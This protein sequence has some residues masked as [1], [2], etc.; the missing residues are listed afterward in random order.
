MGYKRLAHEGTEILGYF[1]NPIALV[2]RLFVQTSKM[3][4]AATPI[5]VVRN[6]CRMGPRVDHR[7]VLNDSVLHLN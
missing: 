1:A 6:G 5:P 2:W 4:L 7:V 3:Y